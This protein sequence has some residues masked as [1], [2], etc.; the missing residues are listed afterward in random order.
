MLDSG[1]DK[2]RIWQ[3]DCLSCG[4]WGWKTRPD[5]VSLP[6][7]AALV[8]YNTYQTANNIHYC[9]YWGLYLSRAWCHSIGRA[10]ECSQRPDI[11]C[12]RL[13]TDEYDAWNCK[14][15]GLQ[16]GSSGKRLAF[17]RGFWRKRKSLYRWSVLKPRSMASL[18]AP[19]WFWHR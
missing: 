16:M 17:K 18:L 8:Q 11:T 5:V 10:L 6:Q 7:E 2:W 19:K 14:G 12:I 4:F 3:P 1:S 13:C 15:P 9:R